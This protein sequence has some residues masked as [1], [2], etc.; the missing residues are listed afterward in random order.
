VKLLALLAV[1]AVGLV[2]CGGAGSGAELKLGPTAEGFEFT[3]ES[4]IAEGQPIERRF[5]CDG[6]N[7]SPALTWTGVPDGA[8]ELAL[9]IEDP[10]APGGSFTHWLVYG[11]DPLVPGLR[12]GLSGWTGY[13]PRNGGE[14]E[15][16]FGDDGRRPMHAYR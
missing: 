13:G 7:V 2:A 12:E 15:N 9:L 5:T 6:E 14:G 4:E 11:I 8:K 1:A 10:D 3:G 16:D